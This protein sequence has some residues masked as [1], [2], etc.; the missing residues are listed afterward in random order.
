[1]PTITGIS[2][3]RFPKS[4]MESAELSVLRAAE[5]VDNEKFQQTGI[6]FQLHPIITSVS[7]VTMWNTHQLSSSH[8]LKQLEY[9]RSGANPNDP[10]DILLTSL[11]G[12]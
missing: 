5:E 2:I 11:P 1:M 3:K 4:G 7:T 10:L 9:E 8:A 6:G 12:R